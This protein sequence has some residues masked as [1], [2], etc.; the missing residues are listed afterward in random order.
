MSF[1]LWVTSTAEQRPTAPVAGHSEV[2]NSKWREILAAFVKMDEL[3]S[4]KNVTPEN[5]HA[6]SKK[7]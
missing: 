2:N 6:Y 5:N 3:E 7:N 4:H 1:F